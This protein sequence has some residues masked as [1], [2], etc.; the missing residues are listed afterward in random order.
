VKSVGCAS[1]FG[2]DRRATHETTG[3]GPTVGAMLE[4]GNLP[5]VV[6]GFIIQA[7]ECAAESRGQAG[8]DGVLGGSGFEGF[9]AGVE[10]EARVGPNPNLSDIRW[11]VGKAGIEQLDATLPGSSIPGAQFGVPQVGGMTS[12]QSRRL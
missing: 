11:N 10:A 2:M 9:E 5:I 8:D 12:M 7:G 4:V 3:L 6:D 1:S